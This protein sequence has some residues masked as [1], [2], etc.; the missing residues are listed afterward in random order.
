M[1]TVVLLVGIFPVLVL[2][3]PRGHV[4]LPA[5]PLFQSGLDLTLVG[6]MARPDIEGKPNLLELPG[7]QEVQ[8]LTRAAGLVESPDRLDAVSEQGPD[9]S[10]GENRQQFL[11][12]QFPARQSIA[13]EIFNLVA[14]DVTC[15]CPREV[16][17]LTRA[18]QASWTLLC[19][20]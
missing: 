7:F 13:E 16:N 17:S 10:R 19:H 6:M 15:A 11:Q 20:Q 9:Q 12:V 18:P 3:I 2:P 14:H 1:P 5:H 4:R 8:V